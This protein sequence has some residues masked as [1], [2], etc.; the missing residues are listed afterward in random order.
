MSLQYNRHSYFSVSGVCLPPIFSSKILI[1]HRCLGFL[2]VLTRRNYNLNLFTSTRS[3][4]YFNQTYRPAYITTFHKLLNFET[5]MPKM[6]LFKF[7][8]SSTS[9]YTGMVGN[10]FWIEQVLPLLCFAF[11]FFAGYG[12]T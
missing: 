11:T 10:M 3:R 1:A 7:T 6:V 12:Y 2:L 9:K 4:I 5:K 8:I